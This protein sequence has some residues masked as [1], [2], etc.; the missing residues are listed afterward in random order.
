MKLPIIY[1]DVSG[2]N[3]MTVQWS[4]YAQS[5]SKLPVKRMLTGP[6]AILQ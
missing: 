5:L 1:G 4:T 6:V 3:P 2:P